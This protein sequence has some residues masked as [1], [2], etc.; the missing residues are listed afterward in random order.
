MI[1]KANRGAG[2]RWCALTA[3]DPRVGRFSRR[4]A[5]ETRFV[6]VVVGVVSF[7]VWW[8]ALVAACDFLR[9]SVHV[10]LS[11]SFLAF[12]WELCFVTQH[13][14]RSLRMKRRRVERAPVTKSFLAEFTFVQ[15]P[16]RSPGR[17]ELTKQRWRPPPSTE[18]APAPERPSD[19]LD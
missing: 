4:S 7:C 1:S 13:A 5:T 8:C 15:D 18:I 6:V 19:G 10:P 9:P 3:D 2:G 12:F 17:G 14:I 11:V 16:F